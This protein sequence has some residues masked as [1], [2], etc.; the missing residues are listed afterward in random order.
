MIW[1]RLTRAFKAASR[2]R[3]V[4]VDPSLADAHALTSALG[5]DFAVTFVPNLQ[6]AFMAVVEQAPHLVATEFDLP[7]GSGLDLLRALHGR[8]VTRELLVMVVSWRQGL[9]EKITALQIGAA[10]FL[11]K[12]VDL[13]A[14]CG[15]AKR[16]LYFAQ[17]PLLPRE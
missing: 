9:D 12:P 2:Y 1:Q 6:A 4:V 13:L 3:L 16:L 14:F 11:G 15:E 5:N 7:D 8:T 17:L 10:H